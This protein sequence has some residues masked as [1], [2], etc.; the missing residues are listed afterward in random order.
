MIS[1]GKE[2]RY[3]H[4]ALWRVEVADVILGQRRGSKEETL[5]RYA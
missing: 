1:D 5:T 2:S 4:L 3:A